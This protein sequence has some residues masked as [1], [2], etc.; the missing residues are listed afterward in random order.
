MHN[1]PSH[2]ADR[3]QR[4]RHT[5]NALWITRYR[6]GHVD[7]CIRPFLRG[8]EDTSKRDR[9]DYTST[10][11]NLVDM[12]SAFADNDTSVLRY[13]QAPQLNGSRSRILRRLRRALGGLL[14]RE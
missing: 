8:E 2:L 5:Q 10:H 3:F 4:S 7:P 11:P 1:R 9:V 6:L 12:S 13:N 14:G